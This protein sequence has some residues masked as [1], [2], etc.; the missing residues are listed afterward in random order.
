LDVDAA[1]EVD[2][3]VKTGPTPDDLDNELTVEEEGE[4]PKV[5]IFTIEI[6]YTQYLLTSDG[7]SKFSLRIIR[8]PHVW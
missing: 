1:D 5:D 3:T 8:P 7:C 4:E 6:F 2:S